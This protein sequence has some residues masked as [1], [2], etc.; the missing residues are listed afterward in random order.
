MDGKSTETE[1][2]FSPEM[3]PNPTIIIGGR[4][5]QLAYDVQAQITIE[6]EIGMTW[7]EFRDSINKIKKNKN[8]GIIMKALRILGNRWSTKTGK[9]PDL[10]DEWLAEHAVMKDLMN[11]RVSILEALVKGWFMETD[12]SDEKDVDVG[13]M[14]IRKKNGSTD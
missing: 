9:K 4:E 7:D 6:E 3:L 12:D 8:T 13:L 5:I 11:Y 1:K 10:T 14:E 2:N